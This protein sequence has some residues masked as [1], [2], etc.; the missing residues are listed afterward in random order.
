MSTTATRTPTTAASHNSGTPRLPFVNPAT[1]TGRA[2]EIFDGPL[3]GKHFNIFKSMANST[4]ALDLYLAANGALAKST[5]SGKEK[6]V[7]QLVVGQANG[8]DYCVAAHTA[9]GKSLGLTDAQAIEARRGIMADPKLNA[10]AAFA[11]SV[12]EKKGGV[13]DAEFKA[14]KAAGYTDANVGDV[15]A[16]VSLAI[17]TNY[18]NHVNNTPT[19]FP[20]VAKI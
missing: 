4:A 15:V 7:V 13:T 17:F 18:F 5:L 10:L 6:E 8:C 16:A 9:I 2:K 11:K 14:F 20:A 1:A 12:N 3:A 19:D